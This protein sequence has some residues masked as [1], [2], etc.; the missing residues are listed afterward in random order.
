M[1]AYAGRRRVR[2]VA[3]WLGRCGAGNFEAV[4]GGGEGA[5]S[6]EHLVGIGY[7]DHALA[8]FVEFGHFGDFGG[9]D[10]DEVG[11][12]G[13]VKLVNGVKRAGGDVIKPRD[14]F[15]DG[16]EGGRNT[17]GINTLESRELAVFRVR[18][19]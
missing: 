12:H 13:G 8:I 19:D 18:V 11:E 6:F 9:G 14:D 2:H 1:S 4:D 10:G 16:F 17:A 5:A 7:A 15:W 3:E